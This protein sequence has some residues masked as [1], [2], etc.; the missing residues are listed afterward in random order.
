MEVPSL[1]INYDDAPGQASQIGQSAAKD[2]AHN[3]SAPQQPQQ[4][5]Q[6]IASD[7]SDRFRI[8]R[9]DAKNGKRILGDVKR[10]V[11]GKISQ[12]QHFVKTTVTPI[13]SGWLKVT[14]TEP[15]PLGEYALAEMTPMD[16]S[17]KAGINLYVWDFGVNAKAP[18][19][20][21]P[22]K[23][24]SSETKSDTPAGPH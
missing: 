14:P 17:G 21:N 16:S 13:G 9:T 24:A 8:I 12:E 1:Y 22:W 20:A 10:Q 7:A 23:P 2:S 19:N 3:A 4:S 11:N 6:P 18:A 15:L 5:Q